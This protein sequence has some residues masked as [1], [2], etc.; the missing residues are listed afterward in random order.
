MNIPEKVIRLI[1]CSLSNDSH[2]INEAR[3]LPCGGN[4]CRLCVEILVDTYQEKEC[5]FCSSNHRLDQLPALNPSVNLLIETYSDEIL[6]R[7]KHNLND[8][9]KHLNRMELCVENNLNFI[10]MEINL[11]VD[12]LKTGLD[13]LRNDFQKDLNKIRM[14]WKDIFPAKSNVPS[15][16]TELCKL[17]EYLNNCLDKLTSIRFKE[18]INSIEKSLIGSIYY[19]IYYDLNKIVNR[20]SVKIDSK[21]LSRCCLLDKNRIIITDCDGKQLKTVSLSTGELLWSYNPKSLLQQPAAICST[22]NGLYVG[23]CSRHEILYFDIDLNHLQTFAKDLVNSP[24]SLEYDNGTLFVSDWS[25][26]S[27]LAFNAQKGVLLNQI[28]ID[29]PEHLKVYQSKLFIISG[30]TI[31]IKKGTRII[32]RITK[33][34]NCIY[35]LNKTSLK[36]INEIKLSNWLSP[37]GLHVDTSSGCLLTTAHLLDDSLCISDNRYLFLFDEFGSLIRQIQLDI[38]IAVDFVFHSKRLVTCVDNLCTFYDFE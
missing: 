33:G 8:K 7:M 10:E 29:S 14:N 17:N 23:D 22:K 5:L 24:N 2:F 12:T 28:S 38:S 6:K 3:L 16:Y 18:N 11:K 27:L 9:L 4:A 32:D 37:T 34:S 19:P 21:R 13:D 26:D 25:N 30:I 20:K 36:V 31:E 15:N 35:V 1:T